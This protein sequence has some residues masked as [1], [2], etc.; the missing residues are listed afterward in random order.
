MPKSKKRPKTNQEDAQLWRVNALGG[1]ELLRAYFTEFSYSPHTHDEFMFAATEGG[2]ALPQYRGNTFLHITGNVL[3]LNPGEVHGGGPARGT[4]WRY[5][6]FYVP[7]T[8]LQ[9]VVQEFSGRDRGL[10]QFTENVLSDPDVTA[11]FLQAHTAFEK[12]SSTLER[13]SRLLESLIH[14]V[15]RHAVGKTPMNRIGLEI[16]AVK[17]AVEYLETLPN[18]DISLE[19]LAREVGL[20]PYYLTRVFHEQTGLPPH[21]YQTLVRVRLAKNLL[22][23]G[24]PISEVAVEAGFF[25]Q[26][27]LTRHFKRVFGVTP[28]RYFGELKAV[29]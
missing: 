25:D 13:E 1:V 29:A 12:P 27:H 5:R 11:L 14:L 2:A 20:S 3:A 18:E 10:P 6:A 16:P 19:R 21:S 24:V 7:P 8:L 26:A 28:G 9:R 23:K 22:A 15:A 4:Y 17:R